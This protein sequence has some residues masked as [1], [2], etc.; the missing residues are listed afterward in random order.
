MKMLA[1]GT[2]AKTKTAAATKG[3][4]GQSIGDTGLVRGADYYRLD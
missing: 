2:E 4:P 3:V 1:K